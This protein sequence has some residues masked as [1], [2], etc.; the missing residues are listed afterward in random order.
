VLL[1]LGVATRISD[2][3]YTISSCTAEPDFYFWQPIADSGI[4]HR[5]RTAHSRLAMKQAA[6]VIL[7]LVLASAAQAGIVTRLPGTDKTVALTFDACPAKHPQRFDR[8][9]LDYLIREKLPA[10][11]F[12]SGAFAR[13]TAADIKHLAAL[14][15]L[16]LENHSVS[17]TLHM[18][19]LPDGEALREM[20]GAW[21]AGLT[22]RQATFFR[23]PGGNAD[24]RTLALAE[25]RYRVVHWSFASGDADPAMTPQELTQNVLGRVGPGSILVFHINGNGHGT[26]QALPGI[27]AALRAQGY[28]FV[29]LED[30][31]PAGR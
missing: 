26:A 12:I 31:L 30:A 10:T 11:L 19:K 8:A 28:R 1:L 5:D 23:F 17:H 16:E 2:R 6:A 20:D 4:L 27:V 22:G 7:V 29:K 3:P 18:E 14:P 9:A 13:E 25:R 24:S 15:F 21:L